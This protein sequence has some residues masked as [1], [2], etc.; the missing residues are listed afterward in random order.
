MEK[1]LPTAYEAMIPGG[2]TMGELIRA[3]DWSQTSVGAIENWSP[4]LKTALSIMLS[5]RFPMFIWWGQDESI[6]FYNDAYIPILGARHPDA[7]GQPAFQ[8]WAEVWDTLSPQIEGVLKEGKAYWNE[9]YHVILHRN[10]YQEETYFTF[11]Y[12]PIFSETGD[13]A[14]IFCA[15]TEET[16]RVLSDRRIKTLRE[17][18]AETVKAKT[19]EDAVKIAIAILEHNPQDLPFAL[20]YLL[21][22][23][24]SLARL[25]A[26]SES[27][28][29]MS[30][31]PLEVELENN[32]DD[33][34]LLNQVLLSGESQVIQ[35]NESKYGSLPGGAWSESPKLAVVLPIVPSG[36]TVKGW[37]I[38]GVSPVRELDS[39]YQ[40]F[41]DLV[42]GQ[43]AT[44]IANARSY[45]AEKQRAEA[46]AEIDRAKTTFFS[47]VSHEFRT[48]L[49]LMLSPLEDSL[50]D[51][52]EP[53]PP[54]QRQRIEVIQRNAMR[55]LKLVNTL[56]D[57]SR[58]EA[59]R[60]QAVYQPTD[61]A[62]LTAELAS[63]FRSAIEQ[64]GVE[65]IVDCPTLPEAIYVDRDLWEKIVLN[66]ISNAFKFTFSGSI[67]VR[68]QWHESQVELSVADT[69]IG[70]PSAELPKL[71]DRFYRV[72]SSRG[73]SIEGSGIGLSLV[74]E[75]VELHNGT[76][77][78]TS[79]EGSGSCFTVAI[80]TGSAHLPS[81]RIGYD[82]SELTLATS[83]RELDRQESS[84]L[85][86]APPQNTPLQIANNETPPNP[87]NSNKV[88]STVRIL[89]ADDNADMRDY[90]ERLLTPSYTIETVADGMT[91]LNTIRNNPPDLVLS[92]VMMPEM[93]GFELL[94]SLRADPQTQEIPIILL[95]AR[96]GEESRIE[97]LEAG[98]DDYLIKPFSTREL[99]ARIEATLKLAQLRKTAQTLRQ[100]TETAEAN[101]QNI[102]TSLRDGFYALDRD[103]RFTYVSDRQLEIVARSREEMIGKCIWDLYPDTVDSDFYHQVH[104]AMAER[105]SFKF[106]YHYPTWDR[107]YE[108]RV[109]PLPDGIAI[110]CADITDRKQIEREREQLLARETEARTKAEELNRLKDEFLAIVSHELR[111]P[112]NPILGW[113]QLLS[114]GTLN[115]DQTAKAIAIVKRNAQLQAQLIEDLL[116]VSRIL[117]DKIKLDKTSVDLR[118]IIKSAI[119]TVQLTAEAK[120]ILHYYQI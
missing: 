30:V 94:R 31:C 32:G 26:T 38:A 23:T 33:L 58:I 101:L 60:I 8:V 53:L 63:V 120:S 98:A 21:D 25:V 80:P 54:L 20:L 22:E 109:Y 81:D 16:R 68:L 52:Q 92:D 36:Q 44:A 96:A 104:R 1:K 85:K 115:S 91:A 61:L 56:L 105:I 117:R 12:S 59:G 4:S 24:E 93:D 49:T 19:V 42:A 17:L 114:A 43:I 18:A 76:I 99:L 67:T 11:S 46:L 50:F 5:S 73:R 7:L 47:N 77:T 70:I 111:T 87:V 102:L 75:L 118:K 45:E 39:D 79:T 27:I 64:S 72:E 116:D 69:G 35:L 41:F 100:Q 14:G 78:V 37:I 3:Y 106:D 13:I 9:D 103:W 62:T 71:F 84:L 89:V 2:G 83:V 66:L 15:I 86:N 88:N 97:G 112:L 55:L 48:P 40:G 65:L 113:S 108:H 95:S 82:S 107:W 74:K 29:G 90:L 57:F 110:L 28:K 34:W 10:G 6:N 119:A 51:T